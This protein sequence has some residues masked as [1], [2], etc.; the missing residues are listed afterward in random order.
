METHYYAVAIGTRG[1][2]EVSAIGYTLTDEEINSSKNL[3]MDPEFILRVKVM[4]YKSVDRF[5]EDV[6]PGYNLDDANWH[7][8]A[9]YIYDYDEDLLFDYNEINLN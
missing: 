8:I 2:D 1:E 4:G 9:E 3:G 5:I 7:D 6:D